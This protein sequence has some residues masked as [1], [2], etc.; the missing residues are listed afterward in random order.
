MQSLPSTTLSSIAVSTSNVFSGNDAFDNGFAPVTMNRAQR[1]S[2][3]HAVAA[4]SPAA[5][6]VVFANLARRETARRA[7][8]RSESRPLHAGQFRDLATEMDR[9]HE[10]LAQ[11]IRDIDGSAASE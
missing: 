5:V 2:P 3:R 1:S 7:D 8:A 4:A 10:R 6:D 9:Q 11:L